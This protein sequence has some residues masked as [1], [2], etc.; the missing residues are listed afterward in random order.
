MAGIVTG[1]DGS[2]SASAA[3]R[4]A[5]ELA[6]SSD[7]P[8]HL[9]TGFPSGGAPGEAVAR[10]LEGARAALAD[11]D[12]AVELHAEPGGPAESL[13]AVAARVGAELI[14]VGNKGIDAR[15]GRFRPAIAEQVRRLAPC[16]VL[17]IDTEPYWHAVEEA[18]ATAP[19]RRRGRI[20]REWQV[21][22]VTTVAVFMAF[23]DVTIVNVAFPSMAADFPEA[24]LS[25]LSWV[26]NA[27]NI[28]FAAA[29]VPAGRIAD[30]LGQRRIFFGGLW[31]FLAGSVLCGLAPDSG[32]LIGA[33]VVQALGAAALIPT[34]LALVLPEFPPERRAV[35][36]SVWA[37]AGA[38]AAATGPSLGGVLI[39]AGG[40]RW[41][42]FVNLIV[43]LG[44][45]P[46]RRLLVDRADRA[47]AEPPD[48]L[49]AILLAGAVGAVALGI[50]KAPDW[51]WTDERVLIC[52]LGGGFAL[53]A[54]GERAR[55]H[56][57]P[58]LEP[59]LLRI[60]SFTV[61]NAA[62][63]LLS[64][65][66]YALLLANVLFLTQVWG[67]SVL[68]AGFGVTPGPLAAAVAAVIGG[69]ITERRGP[70]VVLLPATIAAAV[71]CL[72][73]R[74]L[75]GLEPQYVTHWLP[76]QLLSGAAFGLAFAALATA[77]VMELPPNRLATGTALSSCARQIGAVLGIAILVAVLGTPDPA[78]P[79]AAF[80]EAWLLMA[81]ALFGSAI[82][83]MRLPRGTATEIGEGAPL[84]HRMAAVEIPGLERRELELYGHR[85]V[86]HTAGEGPA[87][88]LVHGLLDSSLTWR[89]LAPVLALGHTVIAPD[90]LGHGESDGPEQVD[91]SLG[92]H[93]GMLRDLLDELG[94]ERV[95][96]VGHS[97][98][99]GIAMSFSYHYPERVERL[100][101]IS[102]GGLGRDVNGVLRAT[103]LP[104]AGAVM[105]TLG[106][107]LP[108]AAGRG[109]AA[110]LAALKLR[111]PSRAMLDVVRTL[112][113]LGDSGRRGA[114]LKTVRAV[115]DGR[116]QKVLALDRLDLLG[117]MPVLVVWGT[118]DRVIPVSHCDALRAA[119]PEASI[120]LM[121]G[122][123]HAPHLSQ[124]AFVAGQL[125]GW[126][127]RTGKADGVGSATLPRP[128]VPS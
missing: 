3:V 93:A 119:V 53:A 5:A 67:Y 42:F 117:R 59:A 49:G 6:A 43:A 57:A 37:A 98:G 108:V 40:W 71:G 94:H 51:G 92:G 116:G 87:I 46:A 111:R 32:F 118:A 56:P 104:G 123:G 20:P 62:M 11:L 14:V 33:R 109:L 16:P 17:V 66:F 30:R 79:G 115:I 112:E 23:L 36:T 48:V 22:L 90:L 9:V 124:P 7:V 45:L 15:L 74:A 82:V 113:R 96:V 25:E 76:A 28:V 78:E 86:Y 99:G 127:R 41:A 54:L 38:V 89:K 126:M 114:Y 52:W 73:Y 69:R 107:R 121:D 110:I 91:Y 64:V 47:N 10:T 77:T 34:S 21:L 65:G 120:V 105:R 122:I 19:G 106:A 70:R 72:V 1:T 88:L 83:A 50:T 101:L 27:Y 55:R 100:A 63:L 60:R 75:P 95:T 97:L 12:V 102:S 61:A 85:V 2:A 68:E 13:C 44:V 29:L 35:A 128:T 26:L 8:L 58:I 24:S 4:Q 31:L 80:D 84:R 125:A 103:T 81:V 18:D 39:D